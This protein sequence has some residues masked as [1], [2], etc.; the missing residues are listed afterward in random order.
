MVCIPIG[1]AGTTL[2]STIHDMSSALARVRPHF[3]AQRRRQGH[4][5]PDVDAKALKHDKTL[6]KTLLDALCTLTQDRLIGI[7]QNRTKEIRALDPTRA[8]PPPPSVPDRA[9]AALE[10]P[11]QLNSI[12]GCLAGLRSPPPIQH[13]L[14][15]LLH[16]TG[17]NDLLSF[18]F[19]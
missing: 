13:T 15:G 10:R 11:H 18:P 3:A 16:P 8:P 17:V 6:I 12:R 1:H 2:Q 14:I 19:W 4:K 9:I 5:Q 7:L